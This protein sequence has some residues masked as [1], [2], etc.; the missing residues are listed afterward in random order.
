MADEQSNTSSIIDVLIALLD[1][2]RTDPLN[3]IGGERPEIDFNTFRDRVGNNV[4]QM[5]RYAQDSLAMQGAPMPKARSSK[6]GPRAQ[7]L[8]SPRP[9]FA[10]RSQPR[11]SGGDRRLAR[12]GR[13]DEASRQRMLEE[14]LARMGIMQ[15]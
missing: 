11:P 7:E 2:N 1:T 6:D 10:Q 13:E 15:A 3:K 12:M 5:P 9:E 8:Q 4:A 14:I